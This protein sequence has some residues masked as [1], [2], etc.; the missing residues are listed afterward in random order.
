MSTPGFTA[1]TSLYTSS[2]QYYGARASGQDGVGLQPAAPITFGNLCQRFPW[3]CQ[4]QPSLSVT[5][6]PPQPPF[7]KGFPGTL[8][9]TGNNFASN[10]DVTLT[11]DNCS[12]FRERTMVHTSSDRSACLAVPPYTCFTIPGGSFTT[13]IQCY[14]GGTGTPLCPGAVACVEAQDASGDKATGTTA[15]PC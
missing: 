9:I 14:C 4:I 6:Q 12:A 11:I 1:E 5:Y 2:G 3:L 13:S 15:I 10:S 8:I 7:G